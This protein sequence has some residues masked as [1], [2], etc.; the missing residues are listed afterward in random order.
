MRTIAFT[1]D[2]QSYEVRV[3]SDG[4][5]IY[6]K[7]FKD[8]QPANGYSYQISVPVAFDM[9]SLLGVSG[10]DDLVETAKHDVT[11]GTWEKF[12]VA[13]DSLR[14]SQEA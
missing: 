9:K 2:S 10:I 14:S 1:H 13:L 5:T 3:V 6:V 12:L 7:A 4:S 11:Q 8:G